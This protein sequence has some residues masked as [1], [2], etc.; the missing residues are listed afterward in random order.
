MFVFHFLFVFRS[1]RL[2]LMCTTPVPFE[3]V[4]DDSSDWY[5]GENQQGKRGYFPSESGPVVTQQVT[6]NKTTKQQT[7]L[8]SLLPFPEI[9]CA[10]NFV[11]KI[12][13]PSA[14]G[15]SLPDNES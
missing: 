2:T 1:P 4:F 7:I 11:R 9:S 8:P 5:E 10:E 15:L 14:G 6:N 13:A 3:R 12:N